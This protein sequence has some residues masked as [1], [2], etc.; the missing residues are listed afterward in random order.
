MADLRQADDDSIPPE[1]RI[2]IRIPA[3]GD[4]VIQLEDGQSRPHGGSVQGPDA[5]EPKS[6]DLSSL[7]TPDETRHRETNGN[8]H[9]AAVSA[10]DVRRLGL[11]VVRDP[12]T[13]GPIPN[14]AHALIV[15]S[16]RDAAGNYTGGLTQGE[17][18]KLA[19]AARYIVIAEQLGQQN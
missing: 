18:S 10:E 4:C 17:Y 16:R 5:D 9:V 11:R 12:I 14:P 2:Y 7:S 3:V 13:D 8:F 1:E 19:R 15:G 6:V